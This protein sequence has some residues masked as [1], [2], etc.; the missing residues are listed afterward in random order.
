MKKSMKNLL[1][2]AKKLIIMAFFVLILSSAGSITAKAITYDKVVEVNLNSKSV[3]D[4][5]HII[6]EMDEATDHITNVRT[7]SKNVKAI[8]DFIA[9]GPDSASYLEMIQVIA[10]KKGTYDLKFDVVDKNGNYKSTE[11]IRLIVCT[12]KDSFKAFKS[13]K[14]GK[15]DVLKKSLK[16]PYTTAEVTL[17]KTGR[18]NIKMNKGYKLKNIKVEREK[19]CLTDDFGIADTVTEYMQNGE[20]VN[21]SE[22]THYYEDYDHSR[23]KTRLKRY[24]GIFAYT[25]LYI[26]YTD[27]KGNERTREIVLRSVQK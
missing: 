1:V 10:T 6:I 24:K 14:I 19:Y 13:I 17:K 5:A 18:L 4:F 9:E 25:K 20:I 2:S 3:S 12:A 15:A 11:K 27:R 7:G 21:L 26:T 16:D 22:T 23:N 8:I